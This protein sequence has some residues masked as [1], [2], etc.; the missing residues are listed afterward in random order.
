MPLQD[1]SLYYNLFRTAR[2]TVQQGPV[3]RKCAENEVKA[4]SVKANHQVQ[5]VETTSYQ[6]HAVALMLM[7]HSINVMSLV[8]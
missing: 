5:D 6:R 4:E 8:G 1:V 7:R 2:K 3:L